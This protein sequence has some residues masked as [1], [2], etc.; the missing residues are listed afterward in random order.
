MG[1]I[2][3]R[4]S[5]KGGTI[6]VALAVL[7]LLVDFSWWVWRFT[8]LTTGFYDDRWYTSHRPLYFYHFRTF[9][10][11][12]AKFAKFSV[13]VVLSDVLC[14]S[15]LCSEIR[16]SLWIYLWT[17]DA[18]ILVSNRFPFMSFPSLVGQMIANWLY[19]PLGSKPWA[20]DCGHAYPHVFI[21]HATALDLNTFIQFHWSP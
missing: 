19:D 13:S 7:F 14:S 17:P 18:R 4:T 16:K 9:I 11:V 8:P 3:Q 10:I 21:C 15:V 20:T 1:L 12:G 5:T 6:Q 2:N